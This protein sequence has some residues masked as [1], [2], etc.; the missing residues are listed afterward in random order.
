MANVSFVGALMEQL[1]EEVRVTVFG[2]ANPGLSPREK[3]A[4]NRSPVG[5]HTCRSQC[6]FQT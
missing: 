1:V 5:P 2:L 6:Q 4:I 3:I